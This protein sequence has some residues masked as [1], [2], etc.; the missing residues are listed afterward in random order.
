M[1]SWVSSLR[2]RGGAIEAGTLTGA[3]CKPLIVPET[4]VKRV[5]GG[6]AFHPAR[7]AAG[8]NPL[9]LGPGCI[10]RGDAP[11]PLQRASRQK[12]EGAET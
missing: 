2:R 9:F 12:N 10:G 1:I 11:F 6:L 8:V 7:R 3:E 5:F 4:G